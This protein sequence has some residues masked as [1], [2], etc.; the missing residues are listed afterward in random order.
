MRDLDVFLKLKCFSKVS[1]FTLF[2]RC[3][4]G[5]SRGWTWLIQWI[6][7]AVWTSSLVWWGERICLPTKSLDSLLGDCQLVVMLTHAV[8]TNSLHKG[9]SITIFSDVNWRPKG[10]GLC[11]LLK[12]PCLSS[13]LVCIMLIFPLLLCSCHIFLSL[14]C[15]AQNAFYTM[16]YWY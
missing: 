6:G 1:E 7:R 16:L 5:R 4:M 11:S 3:K 15:L 12:V 14:D 9:L 2:E 13:A 8:W 10:W